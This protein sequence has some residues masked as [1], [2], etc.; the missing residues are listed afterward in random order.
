MDNGWEASAAAWIADQGELGDFSRQYV[1]DGPMRAR[2]LAAAPGRALDIGCGEGR[3]CR[4]L[5]GQGIAA[6]GLEPAQGLLDEA[7]RRDPEG[8]Y[9]KGRAEALPFDDGA[10]DL[11]VFYLTLIDIDDMRGAVAEAARVLRPGGRVL[12]ANLQPF[13]TAATAFDKHESGGR[14]IQMNRYLEEFDGWYEW[15]G[16][17]IRN[18]HRPMAAYM[19]AF[20]EQGLRL[21][22]FEE[23]RA[24]GDTSETKR[25]RYDQ[26]PYFFMM[27]WLKP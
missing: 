25:D 24:I 7:I 21:T 22:A 14:L 9:V 2:V 15:R 5:R 18:W 23:P 13:N 11:A 26:A 16:I 10:F 27:E 1:L 20:L 19:G 8:E 4:W 17:R 6:V 12:V 3:F